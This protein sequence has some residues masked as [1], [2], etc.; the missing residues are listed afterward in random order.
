MLKRKFWKPEFIR[1]T[2]VNWSFTNLGPK[3]H[4]LKGL[5][6]KVELTYIVVQIIERWRAKV[7]IKEKLTINRR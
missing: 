6:A 2:R 7:Q 4:N 3:G 1:K 5:E